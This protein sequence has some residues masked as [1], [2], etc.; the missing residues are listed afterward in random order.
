MASKL[1]TGPNGGKFVVRR[2]GNGGTKKVY[3]KN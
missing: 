1:R 3:L 2:K